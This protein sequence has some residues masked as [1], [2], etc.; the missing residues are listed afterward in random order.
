MFDVWESKDPDNIGVKQWRHFKVSASS[1]K[2]M[3]TIIM[4]ASSRLAPFNI[5]E[6]EKMTVDDTLELNR[7]KKEKF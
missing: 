1:P 3:S 2:M 4:T 5:A 7:M 6:L